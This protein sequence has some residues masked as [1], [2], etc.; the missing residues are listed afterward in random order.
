VRRVEQRATGEFLRVLGPSGVVVSIAGWML[1]PLICAEMTIGLPRVDLAALVELRR[2]LMVVPN[3][4]HFRS[5]VGLVREVG[6]ALSQVAGG[7]AGS[8]DE[9]G[10][11]RQ[12]AGRD[13][14]PRAAQDHIDTGT[15]PHAGGGRSRRGA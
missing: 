8:A 3:P 4:T 1:D 13:G 10:L 9:L 7:D 11:R 12:Q 15:D 5:D 14:R 2:L 6:N